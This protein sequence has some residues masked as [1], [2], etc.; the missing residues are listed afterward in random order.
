MVSGDDLFG[1]DLADGSQV[2]TGG[3]LSG[4]DSASAS[5]GVTAWHSADGIGRR[6]SVLDAQG[7]L[8]PAAAYAS[9]LYGTA[10]GIVAYGNGHDLYTWDSTTL[11][12]TLRADV[13]PNQA[14][15]TSTALYFTV[16]GSNALYRVPMP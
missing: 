16:G 9:Q 4:C 6:V 1:Y 3:G 13:L 7:L 10:N 2:G 12:S 14:F 11:T 8:T 15:L 5:N